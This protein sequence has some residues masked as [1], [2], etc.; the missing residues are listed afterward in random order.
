M[1]LLVFSGCNETKTEMKGEMESNQDTQKST[2][3][4]VAPMPVYDP[5]TLPE[6]DPLEVKEIQSYYA[7]KL[8]NRS[9][10]TYDEVYNAAEKKETEF[11]LNQK[12]SVDEFKKIMNIIFLDTPE[13]Y[14]LR[15]RYYYETDASGYVSRVKLYYLL[16]QNQIAETEKKAKQDLTTKISDLRALSTQYEV[17]SSAYLSLLDS[18]IPNI[19]KISFDYDDPELCSSLFG[20]MCFS[21]GNDKAVAKAFTYYCRMTGIDS[22]V[23]IGDFI[24]ADF[25][26]EI[27]LGIKSENSS[28]QGKNIYI[29]KSNSSGTLVVCNYDD[30][31]AWNIVQINNQWYHVDIPIASAWHNSEQA[32]E[33]VNRENFMPFFNLNDYAISQSRLFYMNEDIL[34]ILPECKE[35]TFQYYYRTG[36]FF[37]DY[38]YNQTITAINKKLDSMVQERKDRVI[39]QFISESC[40]DNFK[41]LWEEQV[42]KYNENRNNPIQNY[43]II[44]NRESLMVYV[45][46]LVYL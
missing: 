32:F 20:P 41:K 13:F 23:V 27:G 28:G 46:N 31:Y 18:Y 5:N 15:S 45:Y 21:R 44:Y 42:N 2:E 1:S 9:K 38:T 25:S 6:S 22:A 39:I 29:E 10:L 30:L 12:V 40:F 33:Q 26:K 19:S 7:R 24:S 36:D 34:G 8:S 37:L 17:E 3:D 4:E 43:D 11:V 14:Y 35:N 16:T